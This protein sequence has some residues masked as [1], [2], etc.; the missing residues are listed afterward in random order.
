M[1]IVPLAVVGIFLT[2]PGLIGTLREFFFLGSKDNSITAR[3]HDIPLV[4]SYVRLHPFFG[5]GGGTYIP[6]SQLN[7]LDNQYYGFLIELGIVGATLITLCYIVF[8][9]VVAFVARKR[10]R[11]E[12]SRVLGA[13]LGAAAAVAIP[14]TFTFDSFGFPMFVGSFALLVG[15]IGGY[16]CLAKDEEGLIQSVP[17]DRIPET[18][19]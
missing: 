15:L 14:V 4:E 17:A 10:C 8:P 9:P 18:S 3:E 13:A 2:A 19:R 12:T 6:D 16:W 1:L 7:I 11:S 5:K